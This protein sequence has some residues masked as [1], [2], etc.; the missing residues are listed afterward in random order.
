MNCIS[1]C[2]KG[3][4]WLPQVLVLAQMLL[5]LLGIELH[6]AHMDLDIAI[7]LGMHFQLVLNL[8]MDLRDLLI[9]IS[10]NWVM[11]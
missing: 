10:L 5:V 6:L 9:L 3:C 4:N 11:N 1:I 8:L 7:D 2:S